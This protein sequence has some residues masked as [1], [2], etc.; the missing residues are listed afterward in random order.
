LAQSI[1]PPVL[2]RQLGQDCVEQ[3]LRRKRL[4]HRIQP[5]KQAL[6]LVELSA[7]LRIFRQPSIERSGLVRGGCAVENLVHQT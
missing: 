2:P 5:G 7:S 4:R 6:K 1:A 3:T